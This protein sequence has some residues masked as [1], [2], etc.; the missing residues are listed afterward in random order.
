MY[1]LEEEYNR[2]VQE[3][4]GILVSSEEPS[5]DIRKTR[6]AAGVTQAELGRLLN[7][8]RETISRI[9]NGIIKPTFK[10]VK[11][12]AKTIAVA[13][14]IR[15][16]HALEEVSVLDGRSFVVEPT[17]LRSYFNVPMP[18]FKMISEIGIRGYQ[19]SRAKIIKEMRE[20][21]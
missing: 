9:E 13:K 5:K 19:K 4:G 10:F 17:F 2:Y 20:V 21:V 11:K 8:R 1:N 16:L 15:D 7:L 18:D 14:I 3:I 6:V 12:F